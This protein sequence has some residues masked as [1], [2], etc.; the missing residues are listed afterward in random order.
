MKTILI[1]ASLI[2]ITACSHQPVI[3]KV[4]SKQNHPNS[5]PAL[6]EQVNKEE[7]DEFI[8]FWLDEEK[9]MIN[10]K[11]V[12][13]LDEYLSAINDRQKVI[14]EMNI[15]RI[16][17]ADNNIYLL[18]FSCEND[19]CSYIAFNQ[20]QD[21]QAYLVADLAKSVGTFISPDQTKILFQFNR[22]KSPAISFDHLVVIDAE[23][24]EPITLDSDTND[25]SILNYSWPFITID[26]TDNETVTVT[27]PAIAQ[28]TIKFIKDWKETTNRPTTEVILHLQ[29]N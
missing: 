3:E 25:V 8:E 18:E 20:S 29:S 10:L 11:M 14:E 21:K 12:P 9:I 28:P 1:V 26:W 2:L 5:E 22:I 16:P 23:T 17:V 4:D 7:V 15:E 24:W 27:K 19:R 6:V 13:I